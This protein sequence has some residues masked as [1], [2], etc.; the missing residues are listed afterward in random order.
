MLAGGQGT[1]EIIETSWLEFKKKI[2][3]S[4]ENFQGSKFLNFSLDTYLYLDDVDNE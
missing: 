3:P 4:I 1:V 2:N